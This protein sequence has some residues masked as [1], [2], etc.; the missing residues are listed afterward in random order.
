[1]AANSKFFHGCDRDVRLLC[2]IVEVGEQIVLG[3][4]A[5]HAT[6]GVAT[7]THLGNGTEDC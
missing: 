2:G 7:D 6:I 5:R 4:G 3:D 1:M